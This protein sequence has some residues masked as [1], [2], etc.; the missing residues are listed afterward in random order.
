[1][2]HR[3]R[4]L[5]YLYRYVYPYNLRGMHEAFL[6][7]LWRVES[8]CRYLATAVAYKNLPFVLFHLL[9][10]PLTF[11]EYFFM[12]SLHV[13]ARRMAVFCAI[14]LS[15][16]NV[17][18][19]Y[20]VHHISSETMFILVKTCTWVL[21][22]ISLCWL[23]GYAWE[24]FS[25]HCHFFSLLSRARCPLLWHKFFSLN[26]QLKGICILGF[27]VRSGNRMGCICFSGCGGESSLCFWLLSM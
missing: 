13:Q 2:L 17:C 21:L 14:F 9:L 15:L 26:L 4:G 24:L 20:T 6:W 1:M 12:L 16:P 19:N 25:K 11:L 7:P 22:I 3:N 18:A 8:F 10:M 23:V 27:W 5:L